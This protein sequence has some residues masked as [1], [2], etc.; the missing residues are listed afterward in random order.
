MKKTSSA[1]EILKRRRERDPE[2]RRLYEEEK[3]KDQVARQ[4]R[5]LRSQLN[6]TQADL[7]K[8]LGT[9]Q[10]AVARLEDADYEGNSIENLQKVADALKCR[11]EIKFVRVALPLA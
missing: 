6:I 4:I 11:V 7:A 2:L 1:L 10:S 5:A 9:S 8:L 3:L